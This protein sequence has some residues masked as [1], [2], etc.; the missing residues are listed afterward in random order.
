M[1]NAVPG[2]VHVSNDVLADLAGNAASICYGVVGM[3]APSAADGIARLLPQGRLRRGVDV[4]SEESGVRVTLHV[5][6]EYGTNINV[7]SENVVEAVTFALRDYAQ[8]PIAGID[9]VVAGIKVS[10]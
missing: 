10:K 9:V 4:Q 1:P 5:I 8:V 7:V 6:I 2:E 3:A